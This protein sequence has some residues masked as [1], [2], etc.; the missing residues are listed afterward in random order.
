LTRGS[1]DAQAE[2][3][4]LQQELLPCPTL[5]GDIPPPCNRIEFSPDG[6]SGYIVVLTDNGAVEV[7][8]NR[9]LFPV[10][11]K[12]ED[13]GETWSDPIAVEQRFGCF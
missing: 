11:Y 9:S 2:E 10:L 3:N 12:T 5:T 8:A 4:V 1:W 6:Q 7:S 13:G